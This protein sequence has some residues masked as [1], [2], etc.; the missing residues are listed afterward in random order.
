MQYER[1]FRSRFN[2][3]TLLLQV[4]EERC[5]HGGAGWK[6]GE[7]AGFSDVSFVYIVG[8]VKV[9]ETK[10]PLEKKVIELAG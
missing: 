9:V 7:R 4:T 3:C 1:S 5:L 2:L 6:E 8:N 10:R